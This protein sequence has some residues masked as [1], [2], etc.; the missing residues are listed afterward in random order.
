MNC[1]KC[2]YDREKD[3]SD[4]SQLLALIRD[5]RAGLNDPQA[6]SEKAENPDEPLQSQISLE[7]ELPSDNLEEVR[8]Q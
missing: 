8:S 4:L 2:G 5:L 7:E 1:S 6:P 3:L